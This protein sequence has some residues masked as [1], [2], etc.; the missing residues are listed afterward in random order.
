MWGLQESQFY[1]RADSKFLNVMMPMKI[2]F[3]SCV[4]TVVIKWKFNL[5]VKIQKI[6]GSP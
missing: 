1:P 4:P 6:K 5:L 2:S 3:K